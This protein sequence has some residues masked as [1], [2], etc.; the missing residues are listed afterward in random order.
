MVSF[1]IISKFLPSHD[2]EGPNKTLK[3]EPFD[4][5]S[6]VEQFIRKSR[7]DLLK[8]L[9]AKVVF[10]WYNLVY[11]ET[12]VCVSWMLKNICERSKDK[13]Q[14]AINI[15][16]SF[17]RL[18]DRFDHEKLKMLNTICNYLGAISTTRTLE[19]LSHIVS[20]LFSC[21]SYELI[22][23]VLDIVQSRFSRENRVRWAPCID[24]ILT[25]DLDGVER[26]SILKAVHKAKFG[27]AS[28]QS[29]WLASQTCVQTFQIVHLFFGCFMTQDLFNSIL[30]NFNGD[31]ETNSN[32][33][34]ILEYIF[35]HKGVVGDISNAAV[36]YTA[37]KM[38]AE[39]QTLYRSKQEILA[40]MS[41]F[42]DRSTVKI[43]K[44]TNDV[45]AILR[46]SILHHNFDAVE[47][48]HQHYPFVLTD[49]IRTCCVSNNVQVLAL[50]YEQRF[51]L[52][53]S[54]IQEGYKLAVK[55]NHDGIRA[56]LEK[57]CM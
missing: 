24:S 13:Y 6:L 16:K 35:D 41:L 4:Y 40:A 37:K 34:S 23:Q 33:M 5:H 55:A 47:Y 54:D 29:L 43:L 44:R 50:F 42:Y 15:K 11:C 20:S 8:L 28:K 53:L 39:S 45:Q 36:S 14:L 21:S 51:D 46:Y 10:P 48:I 52:S 2:L 9:P 57:Y 25:R 30:W 7:V 17:M 1:D 38:C 19:L 18:G 26:V 32:H 12:N 56:Y 31:E 27:R 22:A 49:E 3:V